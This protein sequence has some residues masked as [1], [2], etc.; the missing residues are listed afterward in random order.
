M[1]DE[2]DRWRSGFILPPSAF[3]LSSPMSHFFSTRKRDWLTSS[4]SPLG[5]TPFSVRR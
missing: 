2:T 3:I 5:W 1:K 4:T